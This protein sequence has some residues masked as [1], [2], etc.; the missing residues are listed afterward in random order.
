MAC[1]HLDL[2]GVHA[3]V[4]DQDLHVLHPLRL[5]HAD[6]LVQ[7]ETWT[8]QWRPIRKQ[9]KQPEVRRGYDIIRAYLRPGKSR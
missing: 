2:V 8:N 9:A 3:R 1:A 4:G 7:Q 6:L 5:V